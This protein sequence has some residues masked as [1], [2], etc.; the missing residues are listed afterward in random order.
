MGTP[1]TFAATSAL[2]PPAG[3]DR[4]PQ[5]MSIKSASVSKITRSRRGDRLRSSRIPSLRNI[6]CSSFVWGVFIGMAIIDDEH[7]QGDHWHL[8]P[9]HSS[10]CVALENTLTHFSGKTRWGLALRHP[11]MAGG[12]EPPGHIFPG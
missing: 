2:L 6:C 5:A 1:F 8:G 10:P 3:C 4:T 11:W 9:H 12:V 7:A